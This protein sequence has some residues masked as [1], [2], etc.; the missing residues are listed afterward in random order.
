MALPLSDSRSSLEIRSART[1]GS[2]GDAEDPLSA[3]VGR[4]I[5]EMAAAWARGESPRAEEFLA[6]HPELGDE[7]AIRFIYE[8]Y[9]IRQEAGDKPASSEVYRRFPQWRSKLGLLLDCDRLLRT[10]PLAEF[11][12][13]GEDLGDF[14]LIAEIGR[15]AHGRT[16][17]ANQ[18]SLAQRPVVLKATP[19]G[20]EEHLSLA[21]LQHM[22]I[23]PLYFEQV[24][25][26][27]NCRVLGMPYLGG[28][29]L[30]HIV[31]EL[32]EVP[33]AQRGG[34][35]I[36]AGIDRESARHSREQ[37]TDGPF[38]KYLAQ[39][40]FERS[41]CWIAACLADALHYAHERG[42]IHMDVKASNV[43]LAGDGQPMLLDFHL[44]RGPIERG[45]NLPDRLGGT[46]EFMS[47][48]QR[49]VMAAIKKG[50]GVATRVDG[51]SD[52]YSLGLLIYAML[53]G[54]PGG[55]R[56]EPLKPLRR[57]NPLVSTGLSDIVARCLANFPD[58][59][60]PDAAGLAVDLNRHLNHQPL[61]GVGNRSPRERW[62]KWR[63]RD[64][65]GPGRWLVR[66]LV[67]GLL[68]AAMGWQSLSGRQKKD[69]AESGL[70][71]GIEQ[72]SFHHFAEAIRAL[73]AALPMADARQQEEIQATLRQISREQ[74]AADLHELVD[75]LRFSFGIT[76][77]TID[78]SLALSGR[79]AV[80]WQKRG[81]LAEVAEDRSIA[82]NHPEVRADFLDLATIWANL[83]V[84]SEPVEGRERAQ[85]EALRI[86]EETELH[87][88]S[89]PALRRDL[90]GYARAIGRTDLTKLEI[91]PPRTAWEHYD[92]G[93]SYLRSGEYSRAESEFRRSVDMQPGEFWPTFFEGLCTFRLGRHH[94]AVSAFSTCI[95][96]AP[97]HAECYYNR[98]Q[99]FEA[100][101]EFDRAR[102]DLLRARQIK[103]SLT[104]PEVQ[105]MLS[106]AR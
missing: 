6:R 52:I 87:F 97:G 5:E 102:L 67:G 19:L 96:L 101:G 73:R 4:E 72:L 36:L 50:A 99:A 16:F 85:T 41:V 76:P 3:L 48:E 60:Y 35:H 68:V 82:R 56:S 7:H 26:E 18:H 61:V 30:A 49:A 29:T 91:P 42:V 25:P 8:E 77:P 81:L 1:D 47:P 11:P 63:R 13:V 37:P 89:S 51:R 12:A 90:V 10:E 84:L 95:A 71:E 9:C 40:T 92:L 66:L 65:A 93:R 75:L 28:T 103:P 32:R 14:R 55:D 104:L 105:H 21:R 78:D 54:E 88:G 53:G 83:L 74:A 86:L 2:S 39:A 31:Q 80:V 38:R 34:R 64:P 58:D 44:A 23:V 20:H 98:A 15:G 106:P 69:Q 22:Y 62:R 79:I 57:C 17:L 33:L 70:R 100:L 45:A 59:R 46:P 43:L 94:D 27:R 24:F